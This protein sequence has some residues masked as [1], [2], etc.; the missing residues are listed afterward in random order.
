MRRVCPGSRNDG[1]KRP[2]LTLFRLEKAAL[3]ATN[4]NT[5]AVYQ[6]NLSEILVF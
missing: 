2:M 4:S 3:G 1:G 6:G 5:D